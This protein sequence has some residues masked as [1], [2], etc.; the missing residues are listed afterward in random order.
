MPERQPGM[1][2]D[3]FERLLGFAPSRQ[4]WVKLSGAYRTSPEIARAAAPRLCQVLRRPGGSCG[5]AT[6]SFTQHEAS[7]ELPR[8]KS[9]P[10]LTGFPDVQQSAATVLAKTPRELFRFWSRKHFPHTHCS[11]YRK[12]TP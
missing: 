12:R 3:G 9:A 2:D 6:G 7:T 1:E 11:T 4:V 8:S 10:S 5:R